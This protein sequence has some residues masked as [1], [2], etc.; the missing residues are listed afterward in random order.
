MFSKLPSARV[1]VAG[2]LGGLVGPLMSPVR[3]FLQTHEHPPSFGPE[4]ALISFALGCLGMVMVWLLSETDPMKALALGVSL[5][6]LF[7]NLEGKGPEIKPEKDRKP[8][9]PF[10]GSINNAVGM[11]PFLSTS[12]AQAAPSST[13]LSPA[14]SIEIN[15][16]GDPFSY[17][18]EILDSSGKVVEKF[19]VRAEDSL[20]KASPLPDSAA[21]ARF[22]VGE[23]TATQPIALDK[24]YT[25]EVQLRGEKYV[26]KFSAAQVFGKSPD[27][28]PTA[29]NVLILKRQKA[30]V[31]LHGWVFVGK[32]QDGKWGPYHTIEGTDVPKVGE[33]RSVVF[34]VF[35][36]SGKG[37]DNKKLAVASVFQ[38]LRFLSVPDSAGSIWAEVQVEQ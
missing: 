23:V 17:E 37:A 4:Y 12:F 28:V 1:L 8:I 13:P 38:R 6:A 10:E 5:P 36:R 31:G 16:E 7:T 2:L 22:T 26:R 20:L 19:D 25:A 32:L 18:T 34:S 27:M 33:I 30:Q 9:I 29:L 35:V 21:T 3:E 14:R 24:G 15:V 11:I